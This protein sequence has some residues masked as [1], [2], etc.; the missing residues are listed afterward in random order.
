[1]SCG[2]GGRHGSDLALLWLWLWLAVTA[3][4]RPLAWEPPHASGAAQ[5]RQ[6][7]KKKKKKKKKRQKNPTPNQNLILYFSCSF[8]AA[9]QHME[10]PRLGVQLEPQLPAYTTATAMRESKPHLQLIPQLTAMLDP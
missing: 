10:V 2:V 9:L 6:K 4:I 7:P 5:K 3:P 1:M 8:R